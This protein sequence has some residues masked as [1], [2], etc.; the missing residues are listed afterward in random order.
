MRSSTTIRV[1]SV[2]FSEIA[3]STIIKTT[4]SI[5]TVDQVSGW[6]RKPHP[7]VMAGGA[8]A[9]RLVE[10]PTADETFDN[11]VAFWQPAEVPR[12]RRAAIVLPVAL[13]TGVPY[14]PR[15]AIVGATRT[16]IGGVIGKPRTY[17]SWR[18]VVD[19]AGGELASLG[20]DAKIEPVITASR[21][22]IEV[23]SARP[24]APIECW[25]AMFDIKPT[26]DSLEPIDLRLYL[27]PKGGR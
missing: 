16:G 14:A 1:A 26:D 9:V 20:A 11:T 19:F 3:F 17:Y 8:G 25:R 2:C 18:F 5:M 21:G 4:A 23:T 7:T 12:G 24:L 10:I 13:G 15:V 22:E 6:N 27:T